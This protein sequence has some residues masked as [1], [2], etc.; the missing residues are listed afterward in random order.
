M[1][2]REVV[3]VGP[4]RPLWVLDIVENIESILQVKIDF[5]LVDGGERQSGDLSRA[6]ELLEQHDPNIRRSLSIFSFKKVCSETIRG[7][8]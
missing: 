5:S 6:L 7:A 1:A 4:L 8:F 2:H 3:T